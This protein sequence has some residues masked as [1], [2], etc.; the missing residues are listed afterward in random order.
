MKKVV[1]IEDL[2]HELGLLDSDV[3][4]W[5]KEERIEVSLDFRG[6]PSVD[7]AM[8]TV[9]SQRPDYAS[10]L[11]RS[12]AGD[13]Q[14]RKESTIHA[15]QFLRKRIS[16]VTRYQEFVD[17][18]GQMHRLHMQEANRHGEESGVRAAYLLF[19]KAISCLRMGCDNLK[20]GYWF[21]GS[22]MREVDETIDLA[23]YF[24]VS[25][26][27]DQGKT[28][29]MKWYRQ[30]RAPSHSKCREALA[31]HMSSVVS[32]IESDNHR[33]LMNELYQKKSKWVHPT[34]GTVREVTEF[35]NK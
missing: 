34:F 12:I 5:V 17:E 21:A 27:T 32:G 6:R 35:S 10:A 24:I 28:D 19:I 31:Q 14:L 13:E 29:L 8:V 2:A 9:F 11:K 25:D 16:L 23:Q 3:E 18:L 7:I 20:A 30:N 4:K 33:L 1:A 22:I 15:K 26:G